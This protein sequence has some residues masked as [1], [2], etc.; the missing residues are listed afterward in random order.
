MII[1]FDIRYDIPGET[2]SNVRE[3]TKQVLKFPQDGVDIE[4][5][6]EKEFYR[7]FFD[8][9]VELDDS[10]TITSLIKKVERLYLRK[11]KINRILNKK[12]KN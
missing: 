11:Y 3:N 2:I 8:T 5:D 1:S 7:V 10:V 9:E 6:Y 12:I 4:Y